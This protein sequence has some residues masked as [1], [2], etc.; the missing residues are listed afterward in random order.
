MEELLNL[1]KQTRINFI[2]LVDTCS[3]DELNEIPQGFGNNIIWNFAHIIASQQV[4]CYQ[5][6]DVPTLM[7]ADFIAAWRAG[8]RPDDFV[9]Q[10]RIDELKQLV[11][12]TITDFDNDFKNGIFQ[13]YN[14]YTTRYGV[15]IN[16]IAEAVQY[17]SLH[18]G[19]HFGYAKA[20]KRIIDHKK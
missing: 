18:D 19:L 17:V 6:S 5:L 3:V 20:M 14:P 1:I 13:H 16:N 4:L 15:T 8:S 12:N 9:D 10:N 2:Q 7:D 11:L